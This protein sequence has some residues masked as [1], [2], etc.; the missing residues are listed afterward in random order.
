MIGRMSKSGDRATEKIMHADKL[1]WMW[2]REK[3]GQ[4]YNRAGVYLVGPS[5]RQCM[6]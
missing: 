2:D 1:R 4:G 6:D 3:Q 5:E